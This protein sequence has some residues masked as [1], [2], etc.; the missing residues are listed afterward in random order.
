VAVDHGRTL[1][2][3]SPMR[4]AIARSMTES[5]QH[6][7]HFYVETE[8]AM[9]AAFDVAAELQ[10]TVTVLLVKACALALRKHPELNAVWTDRGLELVQRVNVAVA[11]ALDGGLIAPAV[12]GADTLSLTET[13][14]AVG[15]LVTRAR[16][17]GLRGSEVTEATFTLSN[18]GAFDV[19]RF[20]AII[21]P[22]QVAIL[23]TGR[24]VETPVVRDGEITVQRSM[25]AVLSAD[26]RALDGVDAARFL[27]TFKLLLQ[28]PGELDV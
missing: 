17:G 28:A 15:D 1:V 24:T 8:V 10:V 26:H 12:L 14:A 19:A 27:S 5:K 18:L 23:A 2:E 6:V 9:D 7:P 3:Q 13:A 25:S 21:V 11:V 4:R 22:P 20:T 16:S